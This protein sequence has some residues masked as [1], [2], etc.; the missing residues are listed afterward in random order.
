VVEKDWM[1][2]IADAT[3]DMDE[4]RFWGDV[5]ARAAAK[6]AAALKI[7]YTS[8]FILIIIK[9]H[10]PRAYMYV[11]CVGTCV[12]WGVCVGMYVSCVSVRVR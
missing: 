4:N 9:D 7:C 2:Q 5:L 6:K 8:Y 12:C 11:H 10:R 3:P 1:E